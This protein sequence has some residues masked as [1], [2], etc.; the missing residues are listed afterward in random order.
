MSAEVKHQH[1]IGN[2][3]FLF[4]IDDET[5]WDIEMIDN[6]NDEFQGVGIKD[7][8]EDKA[9]CEKEFDRICELKESDMDV[10]S[11][12]FEKGTVNANIQNTN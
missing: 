10:L 5:G 11:I 1:Q 12:E 2:Y 9:A 6:T 4:E 3:L 8:G 7:Y